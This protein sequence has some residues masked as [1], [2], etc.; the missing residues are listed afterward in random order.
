MVGQGIMW[1]SLN[2]AVFW[3]L[4]THC[5]GQLLISVICNW[6]RNDTDKKKI[7]VTG[8]EKVDEYLG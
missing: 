4:L 1:D 6:Q 2:D 3:I 7:K 8:W 5:V